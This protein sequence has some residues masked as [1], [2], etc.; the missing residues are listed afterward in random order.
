LLKN[1]NH[2][3]II[4]INSFKSILEEGWYI[5]INNATSMRDINDLKKELDT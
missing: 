3:A 2:L 5:Y 1:E 4:D